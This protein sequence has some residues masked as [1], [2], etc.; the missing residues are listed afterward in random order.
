MRKY[1]ITQIDKEQRL[2]TLVAVGQGTLPIN[3]YM[4]PVADIDFIV[5]N[6]ILADIK[7]NILNDCL[8]I[9]SYMPE[10]SR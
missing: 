3:A 6:I 5:G 2:A 10:R 9:N 4:L 7:K 1:K 8:I